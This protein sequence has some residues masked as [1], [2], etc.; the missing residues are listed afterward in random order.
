MIAARIPDSP[1]GTAP[2][3]VIDLSRFTSS[4][5]GREAFLAELRHAAHDVGF[6]YVVGHGVDRSVTDALV[7]SAREFFSLP[8]E[9]R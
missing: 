4:G 8:L 1:L 6:F 2:L 5:P 3:P 9:R 7:T